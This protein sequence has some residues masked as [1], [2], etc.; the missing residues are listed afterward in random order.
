MLCEKFGI[1]RSNPN[2]IKKRKNNLQAGEGY[3]NREAANQEVKIAFV[4]F[5]APYL[6]SG[7][8]QHIDLIEKLRLAIEK[9]KID[10]KSIQGTLNNFL[11]Q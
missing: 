3:Q 9:I 7:E 8:E 2:P 1:K 10:L 6:E 5:I 4:D 11:S